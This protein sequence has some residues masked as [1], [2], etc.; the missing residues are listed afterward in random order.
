MKKRLCQEKSVIK[1]GDEQNLPISSQPK[2]RSSVWTAAAA[3]LKS[4]KDSS[5]AVALNRTKMAARENQAAIPANL[6]N[7][8]IFFPP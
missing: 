1:N 4:C 3:A 5:P 7:F 8:L 2:Y 6:R